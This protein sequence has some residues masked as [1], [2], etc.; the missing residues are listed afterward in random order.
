M[1]A[2]QRLALQ[3]VVHALDLSGAR[4]LGHS[5]KALMVEKLES[6]R[7]VTRH[8]E[9]KHPQLKIRLSSGSSEFLLWIRD[10]IALP[11][12]I[13]RGW[14]VKEDSIKIFQLIYYPGVRYFLSR[15]YEIAKRFLRA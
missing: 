1:A 5:C 3:R 15:K 6:W 4:G 7:S 8:P 9:S 11:F 14:F 2:A 10:E 13:R 12:G